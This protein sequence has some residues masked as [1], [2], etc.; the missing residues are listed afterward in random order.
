M[1]FADPSVV[2]IGANA[3]SLVRINF[4]N[5]GSTYRLRLADRDITM[6]AKNS[7]YKDKASGQMFDRHSVDLT[8]TVFATS[9]TVAY[10]RHSYI[11]I[12]NQQGDT[13]TDPRDVALG[14]VNY[15]AASTGANITKMLNSES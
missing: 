3:R 11:V 7:S 14:M 4:D 5:Y 6:I 13:L 12:E 2:T 8:E 10:K 1:A 15:L 9:T